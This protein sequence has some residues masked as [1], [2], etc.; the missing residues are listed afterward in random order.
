MPK[1]PPSLRLDLLHHFHEVA[2]QQSLKRAAQ[3]LHLTPPAVTHSLARLEEAL[4]TTLAVRTKTRFQL[5]EAG[6][7]LYRSTDVMFTELRQAL[8]SVSEERDFSGI[9][10]IGV[11]ANLVDEAIDAAITDVIAAHPSSK[12]NLRVGDPEEIQRLVYLGELHAGIGIFFRRLDELAYVPVGSQRF[13]YYISDRHPL[14]QRRITRRD[15]VG[16]PLAWIDA[17]RRDAFSLETEVFGAHPGYRMKVAAY[18][19]SLEG[20]LRILSSGRA[21]VPLPI[22][23]MQS[24]GRIRVARVRRLRLRTNAP[25]FSIECVYNPKLPLISPVR[26]LLARLQRR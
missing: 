6:R 21:I 2:G 24:I 5:T 13:A 3:R 11:L 4:G 14:W 16:Q 8:E 9:V 19:N 18:S 20:G 23:Y 22:A 12:L 1:R 10:S 17:E 25:T 15:L 7:R 26:D